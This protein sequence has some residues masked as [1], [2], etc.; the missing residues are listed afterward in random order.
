MT[1]LPILAADSLHE[2]AEVPVSV[3]I[4]VLNGSQWLPEQLTALLNDAAQ[5][6]QTVIADNGSTDN[7]LEIAKTFSALMPMLIVDASASRGQAFARNKGA[8]AADGEHLIFLDQ[9]DVVAPGYVT[10]MSGALRRSEVV[11]ARMEALTL[12]EG[13]RRHARDLPQTEGLPTDPIPWAYGC[14][15]GVRRSTFQRLRGFRQIPSLV[16]G[17]DIEFCWRAKELGVQLAFVRDALVHY[18]FPSTFRQL[19]RQGRRYGYAG[20]V[21]ASLHGVAPPNPTRLARSFLGPAR[22]LIRGPTTGDRAR[23]VF[24]L[25]RRIGSIKAARHLE[26]KRRPVYFDE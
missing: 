16:A 9:D 4:P 13:W 14:T 25:G 17:E 18:R 21:V 1:D 2:H 23:A 24:L 10:A 26:P 7:S 3:V 22:L 12:N 11:A 6:F 20:V 15:L 19:F 5:P 8:E